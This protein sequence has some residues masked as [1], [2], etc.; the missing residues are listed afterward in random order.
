MLIVSLSTIPPRFHL[1]GAT[2]KSI[3][4]QN[5]RID[6]IEVYIPK[7]YRRFPEH[8]YTR[9]DVPDGIDIVTIEHDLG[10][11]TKILPAARAYRGRA[12]E[13]LFCDDDRICAPDWASKFLDKRR[14]RPDD[15]IVNSG[16]DITRLGF[17][18]PQNRRYPRARRMH[19]RFDLPYRVRRT[20]QKLREIHEGGPRLKPARSRNFWR[21]GYV[22]ILEGC[23]GVLVR[24]EFFD[25]RAVDIP[26]RVWTVDDIWLGGML[27]LNGIG[28]WTQ[29]KGRMPDEQQQAA[30]DA[31]SNRV[32]EGLN[33][34]EANKAC[35]RLMQERFGIWT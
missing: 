24:P 27:E 17:K 28:I 34:D 4:A 19:S 31:L 12:I 25:D 32:I 3:R 11:A 9:P 1:L 30:D 21:E 18:A 7:T 14:E 6:A 15:C 5:I 33:R 2:L 13:I 20:A 23:G 10:P 26:E 22:D 8:A 29:A 16:W 35:V